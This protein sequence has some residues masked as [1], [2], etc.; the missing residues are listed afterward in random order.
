MS[1]KVDTKIEQTETEKEYILKMGD[2]VYKKPRPNPLK[3]FRLY[4]K[5][6]NKV[7]DMEYISDIMAKELFAVE[8]DGF[9]T[10]ENENKV[11]EFFKGELVKHLPVV[12]EWATYRGLEDFLGENQYL[13]LW[14]KQFANSIKN[15]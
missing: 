7:D 2:V 1:K 13:S 6:F 12:L 3:A 11:E 5:L 4:T 14:S 10:L 15:P 9:G 8:V